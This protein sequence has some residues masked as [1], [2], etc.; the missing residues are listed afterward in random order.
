MGQAAAKVVTLDPKAFNN[1]EQKPGR[2]AHLTGYQIQPGEVR[3][4][5]GRPK[6]SRNK[7]GEDFLHYLADDF[8]QH[9]ADVITK[10]REERPA[11][12]L[13]IVASLLPREAVVSSP[14]DP[15]DEISDDELAEMI[16]H[17]RRSIAA[18]KESVQ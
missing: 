8:S 4:P 6:G 14:A 5:R 18:A 9:G 15:F 10:V 2:A 11:D 1:A 17:T 13:K 3:N 7:I 16:D 12:Y